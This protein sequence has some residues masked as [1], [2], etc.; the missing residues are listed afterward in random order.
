MKCEYLRSKAA[1]KRWHEKHGWLTTVKAP[2][3]V[4]Y[5]LGDTGKIA[6]AFFISASDLI[7]MM[8]EKTKTQEDVKDSFDFLRDG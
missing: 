8:A 6:D 7:N 2:C 1:Q 5:Q 3:F 4:V